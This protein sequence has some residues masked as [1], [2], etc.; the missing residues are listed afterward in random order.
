[1]YLF[2]PLLHSPRRVQHVVT[3]VKGFRFCLRPHS[4]KSKCSPVL[5]VWAS[6]ILSCELVLERLRPQVCLWKLCPPP[7]SSWQQ[8][9]CPLLARPCRDANLVDLGMSL[10]QR[11]LC[12]VEVMEVWAEAVQIKLR[13]LLKRT[14]RNL[15]VWHRQWLVFFSIP[16]NATDPYIWEM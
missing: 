16:P 8:T 14:C 12:I 6:T 10:T 1:M 3:E 5:R 15:Q 11:R 9:C 7:F 4:N 2:S 13:C